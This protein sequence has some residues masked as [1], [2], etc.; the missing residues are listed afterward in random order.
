MQTLFITA[1]LLLQV[2]YNSAMPF[3]ETSLM[4]ESSLNAAELPPFDFPMK[5][6]PDGWTRIHPESDTT[7]RN[8]GWKS[9]VRNY[10]VSQSNPS[11]P[12][13]WKKIWPSEEQPQQ[14][15]LG[16]D[17]PV[18]AGQEVSN[19]MSKLMDQTSTEANLPAV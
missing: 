7:G 10:H 5:Q 9:E 2:C 16:P 17:E 12:G 13:A 3:D 19:L 4:K 14:P 8:T 1:A 15:F 11:D 6:G 18:V